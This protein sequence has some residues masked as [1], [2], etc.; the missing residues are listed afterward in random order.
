MHGK[1]ISIQALLYKQ[2]KYAL[3]CLIFLLFGLDWFLFWRKVY[4]VGRSSE[5]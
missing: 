3:N 5:K 4:I 1:P 2:N